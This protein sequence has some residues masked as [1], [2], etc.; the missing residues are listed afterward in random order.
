MIHPPVHRLRRVV[1][2][3]G[4][5]LAASA[6]LQSHDA[7]V[8][9][10]A[11]ETCVTCHLP[12]YEAT[13]MPGHRVTGFPDTCVDCHTT[14]SWRPAL[15]LHPPAPAFPIAA[16]PH[17][18][19]ACQGCHDLGLGAVATA[20]ANTDCVQCHPDSRYQRDSHQGVV[21]P[22]GQAYGYRADVPNFCLSCHPQGR[23]RKHPRDRFPLRGAH[24][25]A[26]VRCH[27]RTTGVPDTGG[28]NT[29]CLGSGCHA[30]PEMDREHEEPRYDVERGDGTN[31]H[32]CLACHPSGGGD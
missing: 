23:A 19:I 6:C 2:L 16:G 30:L 3:V 12:S 32:F 25:V 10:I 26:C 8:T 1:A 29:T 11:S 28:A 22:A 15:G 21:G 7:A 18:A 14:A 9:A 20:G 13:S 27:D 4:A 5:A 31:R 17:G 24:D